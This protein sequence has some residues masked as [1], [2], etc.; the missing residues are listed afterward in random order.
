M[1]LTKSRLKHK[2]HTNLF[3]IYTSILTILK[4]LDNQEEYQKYSEKME[5]QIETKQ[6]S[7]KISE[8]FF[9]ARFYYQN[10]NYDKAITV[11]LENKD[12]FLNQ[13]QKQKKANFH[14]FF[15]AFPI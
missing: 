9:L 12:L 6:I 8:Y 13:N 7:L 10:E 11:L 15:L 4:D 3:N 1:Y 5:N 14:Q 2:L